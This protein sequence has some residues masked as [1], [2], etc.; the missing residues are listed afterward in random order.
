MR[1]TLSLVLIPLLIL[2]ATATSVPNQYPAYAASANHIVISEIQI[3][4]SIADDE[5]IE[6]Y[7]PT[8]TD[9]ELENWRLTRKTATGTESN[10][11][12]SLSAT[13]SAHGYLLI[14]PEE[15]DGTP[16]ADVLYTAASNH[17]SSN[18]TILLYS[19]AGITVVDKVGL[20]SDET[21]AIDSETTPV[22]NP[23]AN[24]SIERKAVSSSS[25]SSM[26]S[27]GED[28]FMGN[29]EDTDNN[30]NDFVQQETSNPQNSESTSEVLNTTPTDTTETPSESPTITITLSPTESPTP[31]NTTTPS[32]T[33]STTPTETPTVT[34]SL[35]LSPTSTPTV[36][37]S[38][39]TT[40]SPTPGA[41]KKLRIGYFP[42][43]N[44][45]CYITY[46]KSF[47]FIFPKITCEQ[48]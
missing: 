3:G 23:A 31:T 14:A 45:V 18:N 41:L 36:T 1:K 27:S 30:L 4:G 19:D 28:E 15:Y 16:S 44:T 37:V 8:N 26:S 5:F 34:P 11:V 7:N 10:L 20:G 6:I 25:T 22:P 29:G 38:P 33:T 32:P 17:I 48:I 13:I 46:S 43:S 42:L 21:A 35:T 39:T 40:P 2:L 24:G 47:F 12:N 9:I